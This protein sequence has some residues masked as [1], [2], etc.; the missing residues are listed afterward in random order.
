MQS[1]T[2]AAEIRDD[3]LSSFY[4]CSSSD[5]NSKHHLYQP[6]KDSW[7]FY[8]KAFADNE[9]PKSHR[10]MNS[11]CQL[12]EDELS[13]VKEVYD[14]LAEDDMMLKCLAGRTESPNES[15]YSRIWSICSKRENANKPMLD[16]HG[17]GSS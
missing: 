16:C 6:T 1:G 4:H 17:P 5:E 8:N 2:S 11:Q 9:Q 7:C 3:I 13:L 14:R 10:D 12:S 15:L